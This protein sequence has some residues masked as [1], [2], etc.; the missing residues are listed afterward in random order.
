[1]RTQ[2]PREV[3]RANQAISRIGW[4]VVRPAVTR[5][6]EDLGIVRREEVA[7]ASVSDD[8]RRLVSRLGGSEVYTLRFVFD[9]DALAAQNLDD[10]I[11]VSFQA[12]AWLFEV[13]QH[14]EPVANSAQGV[15]TAAAWCVAC[16]DPCVDHRTKSGYVSRIRQYCDGCQRGKR[17]ARPDWRPCAAEDCMEWFVAPRANKLYCSDACAEAAR[18]GAH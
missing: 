4:P 15:I 5:E 11:P 12:A 6:W 10:L 3:V 18:R 1:M 17:R 2:I 9:V 13:R 14:F 16:G 8:G 7:S